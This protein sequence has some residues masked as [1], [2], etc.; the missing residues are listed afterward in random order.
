MEENKAGLS[1]FARSIPRLIVAQLNDTQAK[2]RR[3]RR[4]WRNGIATAGSANCLRPFPGVG[5]IV[6]QSRVRQLFGAWR[7]ENE[8]LL[9]FSYSWHARSYEWLGI[10]SL[11]ERR[12]F[13]AI[14]RSKVNLTQHTLK[15]LGVPVNRPHASLLNGC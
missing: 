2:V 9:S 14:S 15:M 7:N 1:E 8:L 13:V 11:D 5:I 12:T 10:R 4:G 6:V 3:S